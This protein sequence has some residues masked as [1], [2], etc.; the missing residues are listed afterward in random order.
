MSVELKAHGQWV[1]AESLEHLANY[2]HTCFQG[3]RFGFDYETHGE[4]PLDPFTNE[5][6]GFSLSAKPGEAMYAP[7]RHRDTKYPQIPIEGAYKVLGDILPE[8]LLRAHNLDFEYRESKV[9]LNVTITRGTCTKVIAFLHDSNRTWRDDP[10]TLKLKDL[11][12]ELYGIKLPTYEDM[13]EMFHARRFDDIPIDPAVLYGCGDSDFCLR[14]EDSLGD[15]VRKSQAAIYSIEQELIPY[16]AEQEL[17][18]IGLDPTKLEAG[19]EV[20]DEEIIRLRLDTFNLMGLSDQCRQLENGTWVWPLELNSPAQV[21]DYFFGVMGL[22][23]TDLGGDTTKSGRK[24]RPSASK[25]S[26]DRYRKEY[27]V[28]DAYLNYKEAVHMKN[29]FLTQMPTYINPKTGFIHGSCNTTGVPTGRC[30]HYD[31]NLAQLPKMRD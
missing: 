19:V 2:A 8:G 5:I 10:R 26:L 11:V 1:R 13:L 24:K 29:N 30:A 23:Q 6:T 9:K 14:L 22:P 28:I 15:L 4:D 12:W 16:V 18:G 21:S 25:K 3:P 20:L 7:L 31:P 27:A 17:W